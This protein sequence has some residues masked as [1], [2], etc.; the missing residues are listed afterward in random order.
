MASVKRLMKLGK[1]TKKNYLGRTPL[2]IA[3]K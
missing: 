3:A 1:G 2:H